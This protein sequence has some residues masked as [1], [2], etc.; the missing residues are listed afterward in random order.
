MKK[1]FIITLCLLTI[2]TSICPM[3]CFAE[4]INNTTSPTE[5]NQNDIGWN[6]L[7]TIKVVLDGEITEKTDNI[8]VNFTKKR[9]FS[10]EGSVVLS[11]KEDFTGVVDL[12]PGDEY[13]ITF[14]SADNEYEVVFKENRL[15]VPDA[16]TSTLT[17][18]V[19]KVQ[20]ASFVA[21]FFRNNTFLLIVLVASS[22]TYYILRRRRLATSYNSIE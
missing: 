13:K 21:T 5:S 22:I 9:A 6:G 19:K 11:R 3:F 8:K 1:I 15:K 7:C 2:I 18:H 12:V 4:E 17:L 10:P 20:N 14:S 16:K